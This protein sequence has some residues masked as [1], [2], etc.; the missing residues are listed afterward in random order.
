MLESSESQARLSRL[1]GPRKADDF[2]LTT[3]PGAFPRL[4]VLSQDT[5]NPVAIR[6]TS[7][8]E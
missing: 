4:P 5:L 3:S 6:S 8:R 7:I 2:K 1:L